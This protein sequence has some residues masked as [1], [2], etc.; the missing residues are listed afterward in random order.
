MPR[1]S[2]EGSKQRPRA[3]EVQA[4]RAAAVEERRHNFHIARAFKLLEDD[5]IH[6]AT[7]INQ[8]G[9]EY[10]KRA[11]V[12]NISCCTEHLARYFHRVSVQAA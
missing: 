3:L 8:Y 11:A 10:G 12:L 1:R 4:Q 9:G 5:L 6:L 2:E 7:G